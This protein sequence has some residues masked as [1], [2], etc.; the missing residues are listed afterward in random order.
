MNTV[1]SVSQFIEFLNDSLAALVPYGD[2]AVE[3]EV[4]N[5]KISQQKWVWF[6]IKDET[7]ILNCFMT[8]WDLKV[9]L[10]DGMKIRAYGYPKIYQKS[11][12]FSITVKAIELVGEGALKKAFLMLKAKLDAE[13]L[14]AVARK[15]ALPRFPERVALITSN[16]AAAYTDFLRIARERWGGVEIDVLSVAVQGIQA[17]PEVVG[18]FRY[19]NA[20]AR[21]YDV[22]VLT[23]GGGSMEDLQAFNS[24]EVARAV[25]G[26]AVPVVCGVGHER[27]ETL[28][29]Y[30]ADTRA[31][32]PSHA[33]EIVFPE[34]LEVLQSIAHYCAR[35]NRVVESNVQTRQHA[36]HSAVSRLDSFFARRVEFFSHCSER[37][38]SA[39]SRIAER[40][41]AAQQNVAHAHARVSSTFEHIFEK[42][43]ERVAYNERILKTLSPEAVIQRG[44][45]IIYT[46]DGTKPVT[47]ISQVDTGDRIRVKL[48]DGSLLAE[49]LKN[50]NSL[51]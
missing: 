29:D 50:L 40:V 45:S 13:G 51:F 2:V 8:T 4:A 38:G 31:A 14:F 11:G 37:V 19:I 22:C 16:S 27:D 3:G 10:E 49:A 24:E 33:A 39:G 43:F 15:R 5:F 36:I 41:R 44:Y 6:D 23:R 32:T 28:A 25:Y 7:G 42:I 35:V 20:H 18:A 30:V 12:K 34:R 46:A 47:S 1:F 48:K 26:S 9:P 17:I 21:E